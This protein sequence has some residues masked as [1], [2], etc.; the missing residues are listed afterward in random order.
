MKCEL[1]TSVMCDDWIL[2]INIKHVFFI[3][4]HDSNTLNIASE[5]HTS[6]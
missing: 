4:L 1:I 6:T 2:V 5:H 3:K